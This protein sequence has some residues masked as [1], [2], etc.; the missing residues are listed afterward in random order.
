[1]IN[2][3]LITAFFDKHIKIFNE[4][5]QV[6]RIIIHLKIRNYSMNMATI[7]FDIDDSF[8]Y[9]IINNTLRIYGN[10]YDD[11]G[12]TGGQA[13]EKLIDIDFIGYIDRTFSWEKG[14]KFITPEP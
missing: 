14:M 1:M 9:E 13:F 12:A 2:K 4:M 5:G 8:Q 6:Q 10:V 7:A 11:S 3:E